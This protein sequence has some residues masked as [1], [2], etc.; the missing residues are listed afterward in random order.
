MALG[1][2]LFIFPRSV[3]KFPAKRWGSTSCLSSCRFCAPVGTVTLK[4]R[5]LSPVAR[6]F[7]EEAREAA[8]TLT[9]R[10][11]LVAPKY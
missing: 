11:R 5:T 3:L 8:K 6:I 4:N 10:T 1:R 9:K 2:F 7:I